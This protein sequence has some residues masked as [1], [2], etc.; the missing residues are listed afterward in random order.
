[1]RFQ[2]GLLMTL[3]IL[4]LAG[5]GWSTSYHYSGN[6]GKRTG[7]QMDL[8]RSGS[9][10][11]GSYWYDT[12]GLRLTLI[13]SVRRGTVTVKEFEGD[14]QTGTFTGTLSKDDRQF[15]G[16]WKSP[17]GKRSLPFVLTANAEYR[18]LPVKRKGYEVSGTYPAFLA[19]ASGWQALTTQLRAWVL[20][21]QR[22]FLRKTAGELHT[23]P[24]TSFDY[25]H[26]IGVAY[27]DGDLVSL[28]ISVYSY[29]GGAHQNSWNAS[30]NYLITG[31]R[32]RLLGLNDLFNPGS[33]YR[34]ALFA[35]V[36]ADLNRQKA[37]R[38]GGSLDDTFT[39]DSLNVYTI[40]PRS[41]TFFFAQ[42]VAGSYAEGPYHVT[43]PYN[44]LTPYIHPKGPLARFTV[45]L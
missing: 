7:V 18:T 2:T 44:Q 17:D 37:A 16:T 19:T 9:E 38:D 14:M 34:E 29:T 5:A 42:Y 26:N 28:L 1:M 20:D 43:I 13:G 33:G 39:A 45:N 15:R 12:A 23:V 35:L 8:E 41:I 6:I 11:T 4:L 21:A 30:A 25:D 22:D 10:L 36:V 32:P 24:G 40:S 27:V 3:C 31:N